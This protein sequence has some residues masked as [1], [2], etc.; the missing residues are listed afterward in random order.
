MRTRSRVAERWG[1]VDGLVT[2]AGRLAR[3]SAEKLDDAVFRDALTT[4]VLGTWLA[5]RSSATRGWSSR[6]PRSKSSGA[7]SRAAGGWVG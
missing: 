4:N 7:T 3:G 6:R 5:I 2:S 1:R